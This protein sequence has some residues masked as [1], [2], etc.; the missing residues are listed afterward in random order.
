VQ[1]H[2]TLR[3]DQ[4]KAARE[5]L[6]HD[7]GVLAATTAFGKTVV[8]A[9]LLAQ[10]GVNTLILVHRQQLL[11]QW[12][13]RLSAFLEL[14]T[15]NLG[16]LGGG[17]RRLTG[18]VDVALIQS[19]VRK[20]VVDDQVGR[21][22]HL[23]VDECHHLSARSFELVARRAKAKFVTGL[24]ATLTRKDGHHPIIFMQCGPIRY[25][26]DARSQ[27]AA[28]P[29]T[30]H[31]Y[32]RPTSFHPEEAEAPDARLE[33][34]RLYEGLRANAA[35]NQMICSDVLSAVAESRK[36]LILTERTEH[37]QEL[38]QRLSPEVSHLVV[39]QGGQ[40]ESSWA[41]PWG[42]SHRLARAKRA[43]SS[44]PESSSAR[45]LMTR[46][47]TRFSWR[48]RSPGEELL[49]ITW[50]ACSGCTMASGKFES[51]TMR[52]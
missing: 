22:G 52:I 26:I 37:L 40:P 44:P 51:M 46:N 49:P 34:H 9:W 11:E 13:E 6:K 31:V 4:D 48:Y 5:L 7:T 8:A 20:G 18:I 23:I 33:F 27:A 43:W 38:A 16:R 50:V 25:R 35:R 2:G 14:P 30:H 12:M 32:V 19:L 36:P 1:F 15:E 21:Y 29:F 24:S 3:P 10:R 17:R 47:W 28:R 41:R 42:A 39:L 45:G